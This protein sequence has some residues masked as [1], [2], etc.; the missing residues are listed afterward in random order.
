M[1][2]EGN[3]KI[4]SENMMPIIKKETQAEM[5]NYT[6]SACVFILFKK[7][8]SARKSS[9][10]PYN[11]YV[12]FKGDGKDEPLNSTRP[13]Y[14]KNPTCVFILFKKIGSARKSDLCNI[15]F[16]LFSRHTDPVVLDGQLTA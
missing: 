16:N 2:R 15:V 8:G 14:A 12:S 4:S 6:V 10:M 3:I 1:K 7:I 11:I 5:T 13:L 9:F